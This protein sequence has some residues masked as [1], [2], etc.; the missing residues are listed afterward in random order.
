MK[1]KERDDGA[2]TNKRSE[3]G[4]SGTWSCCINSWLVSPISLLWAHLFY[5]G[6]SL[7]ILDERQMNNGLDVK[8][9]NCCVLLNVGSDEKEELNVE[10]RV[11]ELVWVSL[12]ECDQEGKRKRSPT[13]QTNHPDFRNLD[14]ATFWLYC[15]DVSPWNLS[16]LISAKQLFKLLLL[17]GLKWSENCIDFRLERTD[18]LFYLIMAFFWKNW[19]SWSN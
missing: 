4:V 9:A 12:R 19:S 10:K 16:S 3:S 6:K 8:L 11:R 18:K 13:R 7:I 17:S 2:V 1:V 14:G 15:V 5:C